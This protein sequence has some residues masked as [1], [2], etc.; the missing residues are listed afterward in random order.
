MSKQL[1]KFLRK[2]KRGRNNAIKYQD[3]FDRAQPELLNY[4]NTGVVST[5]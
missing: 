1:E 2:K 3:V 4:A 5:G